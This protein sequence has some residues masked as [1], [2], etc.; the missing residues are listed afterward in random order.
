MG[1]E[2]GLSNQFL[3]RRYTLWLFNIA[4]VQM[5]NL[6]MV[7]LLKM[8]I[9]HGCHNQM[10]ETKLFMTRFMDVYTFSFFLI[11]KCWI[12]VYQQTWRSQLWVD[13]MVELLTQNDRV[14]QI[15]HGTLY[16]SF[17]LFYGTQP[18]QKS[19]NQLYMYHIYIYIYW[20]F[21]NQKR[22]KYRTINQPFYGDALN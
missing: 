8:V 22:R 21:V 14:N 10:V 15:F 4:M 13:F 6:Q 20:G 17:F 1:F 16:W 18:A 2:R 7:Y 5:A 19:Y 12:G 9:F 3:W 11:R